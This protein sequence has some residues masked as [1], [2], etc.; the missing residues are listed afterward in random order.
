M[1]SQRYFERDA[2][3]VLFR[4]AVDEAAV[5]DVLSTDEELERCRQLLRG[6]TARP[7]ENI[8]KETMISINQFRSTLRN[9]AAQPQHWF[10]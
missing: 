9:R 6:E 7:S 1:I 4:F 8:A 10:R 2:D 5:F 3:R